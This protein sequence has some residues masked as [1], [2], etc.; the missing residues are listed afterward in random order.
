MFADL[1][2]TR[3]PKRKYMKYHK[4][5]SLVNLIDNRGT[6][7]PGFVELNLNI[8]PALSVPEVQF[9]IFSHLIKQEVVNAAKPTNT[10]QA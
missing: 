8:R 4:R 7:W 9:A 1:R 10:T 3:K 6:F 5:L 2:H